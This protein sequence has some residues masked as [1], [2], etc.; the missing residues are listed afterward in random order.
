M[1][2]EHP[3]KVDALVDPACQSHDLLIVAKTLTDGE[4][5]CEQQRRI[6]RRDFAVPTSLAGLGIEPMIEPTMLLI[7][8]RVEE[9][10]RVARAFA[11]LALSIQFRSAAM[12]SDVRPKPVAAMLATFR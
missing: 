6:D 4:N 10:Q 3:A 1:A 8:A 9:A 5:T 2:V 11:R 7:G 12:Q